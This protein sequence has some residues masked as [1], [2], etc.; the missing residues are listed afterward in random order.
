MGQ[1]LTQEDIRV[2]RDNI[3]ASIKDHKQ[4]IERLRLRLK[5]LQQRCEH[6]NKQQGSDYKETF[7]Y[8]PDCDKEF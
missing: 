3:Y 4:T 6:P 1:E 2:D 5:H 8:C 7:M